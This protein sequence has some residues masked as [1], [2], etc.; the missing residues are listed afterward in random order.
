LLGIVIGSCAA[1]EGC[2]PVVLISPYDAT[3]ESVLQGYRYSLN[4]LV[5]RAGGAAGTAAGTFDASKDA[6]VDLEAK[7]DGLVAQAKAQDQGVGCKLDDKTWNRIKAQFAKAAGLP[8][9]NPT[10]GDGDGYGCVTMM[11]SNVQQNLATLES[12]HKDPAQCVSKVPEFP[13][14]LRPAA[15]QDIVNISNQTIDAALFVEHALKKQETN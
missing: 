7:I 12:I 2:H 1:I 8:A 13:T 5:K 11:L 15:A 3:V 9:S 6:Y 4:V 14:C 10:T